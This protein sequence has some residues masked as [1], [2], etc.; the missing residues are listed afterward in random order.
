MLLT[1]WQ[2]AVIVVL[3]DI[4]R[5]ALAVNDRPALRA[6]VVNH[7]VIPAGTPDCEIGNPHKT[8]ARKDEVI[9]AGAGMQA[10]FGAQFLLKRGLPLRFKA[11]RFFQRKSQR[12][13]TIR[14]RS[15]SAPTRQVQSTKSGKSRISAFRYAR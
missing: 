2:V 11:Q 10:A 14:K 15:S 3:M 5:S 4:C 1:V 8:G 9:A 7:P 13:P 12:R 6:G